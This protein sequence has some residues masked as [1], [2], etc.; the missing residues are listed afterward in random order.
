VECYQVRIVLG[1]AESADDIVIDKIKFSARALRDLQIVN[2]NAKVLERLGK[3][4]IRL[5]VRVYPII[6]G[7]TRGC[8]PESAVKKWGWFFVC[9]CQV[10]YSDGCSVK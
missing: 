8:R 6:D 10:N 4:D 3:V 1:M 7:Y 2:S 5:I 9:F